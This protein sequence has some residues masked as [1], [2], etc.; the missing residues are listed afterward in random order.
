MTHGIITYV[1]PQR[2]A[3]I[4]PDGFGG[5]FVELYTFQSVYSRRTLSNLAG[6]DIFMAVV[7]GGYHNIV[8][9]VDANGYPYFESAGYITPPW[10]NF[11]AGTYDTV[12]AIFAK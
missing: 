2:K 5:V 9:G 1:G 8:K 10:T 11:P 6:M 3:N 12:I 4:T 7:K